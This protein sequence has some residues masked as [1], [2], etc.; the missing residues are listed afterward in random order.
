M[1]LKR[2]LRRLLHRDA[3]AQLYNDAFCRSSL[4]W[5]KAQT[6]G[7]SVALVG[8]AQ[9]LLGQAYGPAIDGHDVVIRLNRGLIR[10]PEAQ[11]SR[12]DVLGLAC[13]M[14]MSEIR[15]AFGNPTL[16]WLTPIR[17][18]MA[19]DVLAMRKS[20]AVAPMDFWRDLSRQV[21]DAR[22]S[23]GLIMLA[24][25]REFGECS[26]IDL[27]GFDFKQSKTF[28]HS[29]ERHGREVVKRRWHDWPAEHSLVE[30]WVLEDERLKVH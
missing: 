21:G 9:S 23:A 29:D 18:L 26:S 17:E 24:T 8:N 10:Y 20:V 7:R 19:N 3:F 25:L 15:V 14:S 16:A 22:P 5:L 27:F 1:N 4:H 30:R 11:G 28:Y 13:D 2:S 6:A 12:A